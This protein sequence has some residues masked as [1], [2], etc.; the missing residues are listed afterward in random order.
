MTE[1]QDLTRRVGAM[2]KAHGRPRSSCPWDGDRGR[3]WLEGYDS[4]EAPADLVKAFPGGGP[5]LGGG[6]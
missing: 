2:A 4:T 3:W 5:L 1:D 6:F